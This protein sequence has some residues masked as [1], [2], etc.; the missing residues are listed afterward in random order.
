MERQPKTHLVC[1]GG[2][3][4]AC[5]FMVQFCKRYGLQKIHRAYVKSG[6]AWSAFL[7]ESY[8]VAG[9]E[10]FIDHNM[11]DI[12]DVYS[13]S[14]D[15]LG[16]AFLGSPIAGFVNHNDMRRAIKNWIDP[17]AIVKH[18]NYDIFAYDFQTKKQLWWP[19]ERLTGLDNRLNHVFASSSIGGILVPF[20][21]RY[22][23]IGLLGMPSSDKDHEPGDAIDLKAGDT[24]IFLDAY[25]PITD[26]LTDEQMQNLDYRDYLDAN[27]QLPLI[28]QSRHY[29][30]ELEYFAIYRQAKFHHVALDVETSI[31]DFSEENIRRVRES[32]DRAFALMKAG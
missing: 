27:F 23:D 30:V 20:E 7:L 16:G 2:G 22:M 28:E 24:L 31:S 10:R 13:I 11:T 12:G 25:K 26:A 3:I 5:V 6:S 14:T 19:S 1:S 15:E 29:A 17:V 21:G 8:G 4:V 32:C 9:A 18:L